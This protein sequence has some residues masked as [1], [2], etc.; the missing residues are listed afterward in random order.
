MTKKKQ[1]DAKKI[2]QKYGKQ[3]NDD[4]DVEQPVLFNPHP[5]EMVELTPSMLDSLPWED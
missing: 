1:E 5:E 2:E 4:I 3:N